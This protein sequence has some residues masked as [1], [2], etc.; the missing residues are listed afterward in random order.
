MFLPT[1]VLDTIMRIYNHVPTIL[2]L[3]TI[4]FSIPFQ[5]K[6]IEGG[7]CGNRPVLDTRNHDCCKDGLGTCSNPFTRFHCIT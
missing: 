1:I 4:T 2:L 7:R 6:C 5:E 3:S